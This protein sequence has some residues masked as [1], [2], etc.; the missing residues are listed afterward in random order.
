MPQMKIQHFR[1]LYM[2]KRNIRTGKFDSNSILVKKKKER[3]REKERK[4]AKGENTKLG[5]CFKNMNI[6][7]DYF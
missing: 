3:E 4:R 2:L 1:N 6:G 5:T 7:T